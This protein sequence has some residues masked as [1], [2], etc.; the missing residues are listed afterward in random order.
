M[1]TVAQVCFLPPK[2]WTSP[3]SVFSLITFS[4]IRCANQVDLS[5]KYFRSSIKIFNAW[6]WRYCYSRYSSCSYAS[7]RWPREYYNLI[8]IYQISMPSLAPSSHWE[9]SMSSK[10]KVMRAPEMGSIYRTKFARFESLKRITCKMLLTKSRFHFVTN[11][12]EIPR[13]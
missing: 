6:S 7:T 4:E 8:P 2:W 3:F 12:L 10:L 11:I 1:I 13:K 9:F 5:S